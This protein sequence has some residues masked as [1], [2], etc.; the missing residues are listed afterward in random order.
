M[1]ILQNVV[2]FAAVLAL[3]GCTELKPFDGHA[4]ASAVPALLTPADLSPLKTL[5]TYQVPAAASAVAPALV[6]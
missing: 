2:R 1:N 5:D 6:R 4:A 3:A